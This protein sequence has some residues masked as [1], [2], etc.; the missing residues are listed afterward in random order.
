MEYIPNR[1]KKIGAL[2]LSIF[3]LISAFSWVNDSQ[4]KVQ[5]IKELKQENASLKAKDTKLSIQYTQLSEQY[6]TL[7][8]EKNG[9]ANE[10]LLTTTNE[11]F[12]AVY[13]YDTEKKSDSVAARK[14]KAKPYANSSTLD[15]LFSK[16]PE[17]L[18]TTVTTVS[19]LEGDPEVYRMSSD[20]MNL[21][22]MVLV[23]YSLS[24]A[25]SEKQ[26]SEFMYKIVF[27]PTLKQVT[28]VKNI[29]QVMI[30]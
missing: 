7:N 16:D 10:S 27:D 17:K 20:E 23:K 25:G 9:S 28:E 30:P 15:A 6:D 21:T 18:T 22:A 1:M 11:L 4:K 26:E 14:E 2:F 29:G 13:N 12:K 3:L 19:K 8:K 5:T 24:I